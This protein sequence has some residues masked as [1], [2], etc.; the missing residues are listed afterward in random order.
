[1]FDAMNVLG[2]VHFGESRLADTGRAQHQ[3]VSNPFPQRQ[4]DLHF[5]GLDPMQ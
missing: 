2:D 5:V 1:M 4:T 3:G